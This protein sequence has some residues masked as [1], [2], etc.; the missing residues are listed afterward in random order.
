MRARL[1]SDRHMHNL[2]AEGTYY[3][4]LNRLR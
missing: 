2:Q 4:I 3:L 1:H